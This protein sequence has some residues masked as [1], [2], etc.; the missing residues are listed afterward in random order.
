[1][2]DLVVIGGGPGGYAAAIRATQLGGKVALVESAEIGGTCVNHG[3]IPSKIWLKAVDLQAAIKRGSEFGVNASLESV[4]TS[5]IVNRRNG[6]PSDIRMGMGGLLSNNGIEVIQ[7]SGVLKSPVEVDV[8]GRTLET[9]Q[10]IIATGTS[11]VTPDIPG[12]EA[13]LLTTEQIFNAA[14]G[15]PESV[16]ISGAGHIEVEMAAILNGFGVKVYLAYESARILPDEDGDTGQRMGQALRDQ[17]IELL[18][19]VSLRGVK[20]LGERFEP[21]LTG[22]ET[23]ITVDRVLTSCRRPNTAGLSLDQAGVSVNNEGFIEVDSRQKTNVDT[24]YAI[25]DVTGGWMLSYAATVMGVTAA[26][27]AFGEPIEFRSSLVPRSIYAYPEAAAVGLSEEDAEEKGLDVETGDFPYSINALAMSYGELDGAVKIVSDAEY[28]EILGVHIVGP[29][30]AELIWGAALAMRLEATAEDLAHTI[31]M[32]PTF[33]ESIAMA[34]QD[35]LGWA[36]YLP[37]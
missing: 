24:I 8:D 3:C 12:L 36:L 28:G 10:I 14:N 26:Q 9:K 20:N 11:Q 5:V 1:M 37:K 25:G 17:G 32:H 22:S 29:R 30:A 33:S 27:N 4:D 34:A 23:A 21:E 2:Y 35:A 13:A 6:I 7:G 31:V 18:P 19:R 15:F 16:L